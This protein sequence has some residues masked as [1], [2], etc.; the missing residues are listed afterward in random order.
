MGTFIIALFIILNFGAGIVIACEGGN[1]NFVNPIVIYEHIKIN[2]FG[3]ILLTILTNVVCAPLAI[4]YWFYKLC[5][6][7]RKD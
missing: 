7:G 1:L 6:V 5:T 2:W 3:T 4:L